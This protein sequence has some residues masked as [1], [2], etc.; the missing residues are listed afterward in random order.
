MTELV[1]TKLAITGEDRVRA[2]YKKVE[3]GQSGLAAAGKR[4]N[5][6]LE[7]Q[8]D[9]LRQ[10]GIRLAVIT[11][12]VF[13][14]SGA[15]RG[16]QSAANLDQALQGL[17]SLAAQSGRS[18]DA[19]LK[20]VTAITKQQLALSG[21]VRQINLALASGFS[22]Q[23]IEDLTD[24]ATKASRVLGVA[25]PDA[26]DRLIKAAAKQ[27]K[28]LL[29]EIGIF[30]R[31]GVASQNY[32]LA[33]GKNVSEL[34]EFE[35]SQAFVNA[36]IDEGQRKFGQVGD[37]AETSAETFNRLT[38]SAS[39]LAT[40]LGIT[41]ANIAAPFARAL[42]DNKGVMV[43]AFAAL[44]GALTIA[45]TPIIGLFA[46]G[47]ATALTAGL[48]A[49]P[50]AAAL[51]GITAVFGASSGFAALTGQT[52][53]FNEL[54]GD[55]GNLLSRLISTGQS[56]S[57]EG[58]ISGV[59]NREIKALEDAGKALDTY[60]FKRNGAF[61]FIIGAD[62]VQRTGE[63]VRSRINEAVLGIE[64]GEAAPENPIDAAYY[65]ASNEDFIKVAQERIRAALGADID[66][67]LA[68]GLQ[69]QIVEILREGTK[70][71]GRE[72]ELFTNTIIEGLL[73]SAPEIISRLGNLSQ[74]FSA[75]GINTLSFEFEELSKSLLRITTSLPGGGI[76][77][78]ERRSLDEVE[79]QADAVRAID[80]NL[81]AG[82]RSA[83]AFQ[84]AQEASS[85]TFEN[86][87]QK[88]AVAEGSL[89]DYRQSAITLGV[90]REE[91]EENIAT[92]T[93]DRRLIAL[94]LLASAE[95]DLRI[96]QDNIKALTNTLA[97]DKERL[98]VLRQEKDLQEFISKTSGS[99]N[100]LL[101]LVNTLKSTGAQDFEIFSAI[102]DGF[103]P[104]AVAEIDAFTKAVDEFADATGATA[105][106]K[107]DIL[108]IS[109]EN[110]EEGLASLN[111]HA[112]NI[113]A[114]LSAS[115][116]ELILRT[117]ELLDAGGDTLTTETR[118]NLL[119]TD[120]LALL[121][122]QQ[123]LQNAIGNSAKD[124]LGTLIDIATNLE[125]RI[126]AK[127]SSVRAAI[128][129]IPE[130]IRKL[131]R[132]EVLIQTRLAIDIERLEQDLERF[133]RE[134]LV[135]QL[136]LNAE[137]QRE[138]AE[139]NPTAANR[140][141]LRQVEQILHSA[142]LENFDLQVKQLQDQKKLQDEDL[143]ARRDAAAE[144]IKSRADATRQRYIQ[145][146]D[147]LAQE[148]DNQEAYLDALADIYNKDLEAEDKLLAQFKTD[149]SAI[150]D[151]L[152]VSQGGQALNA[153]FGNVLDSSDLIQ[154]AREAI[155]RA[156]TNLYTTF[157]TLLNR[158]DE[159]TAKQ[160]ANS[161]MRFDAEQKVL[162]LSNAADIAK[163]MGAKDT[164][165]KRKEYEE[166]TK[167]LV[168][169]ELTSVQKLWQD[170]F[171]DLESNV[172]NFFDKAFDDI[173]F[174]ERGEADP[175]GNRERID[176]AFDEFSKDTAR[177]LFSTF[178][179]EPAGNF[180]KDT[181][182]SLFNLP[183]DDS[184]NVRSLKDLKMRDGAL[185]TYLVGSDVA[186]G[187]ERYSRP[188][189]YY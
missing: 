188:R 79:G 51:F 150:I 180:V 22:N 104:T 70:F 81:K 147:I 176:D 95:E 140:E 52:R 101:N 119:H 158:H 32:A 58:I 182:S 165:E 94:G 110:A 114:S 54:L 184:E 183:Q 113:R 175:R 78:L 74:A 179:S 68:A 30:A 62:D 9:A 136:Q 164:Y 39:D 45:L 96:T 135:G 89:N 105:G 88:V 53:Q 100:E 155:N 98:A 111:S 134:N 50:I 144:D 137:F 186:M 12:A 6:T 103:D 38:A 20:N 115:G 90:R 163:V 80:D 18:G 125:N 185:E 28:E 34:T 170:F 25:L 126:E 86:F 7:R 65:F 106:L 91:L 82:I 173:L 142:M 44:F 63:D 3:A 109:I 4:V 43:A 21:T 1:L 129:R 122:Q 146:R 159:V 112:D 33:L 153:T 24:V 8:R 60:T 174:G 93:G 23:Q 19:I 145:Q 11:G 116:T 85:T 187:A 87:S 31:V 67:R 123:A 132:E 77:L 167:D 161:E 181:F 92:L 48:A 128:A 10:T 127:L 120:R 83:K 66:P 157:A 35:K 56:A 47:I 15:F 130:E 97:L 57:S 121:G 124:Q 16:L 118:I 76:T 172:S 108:G 27:E 69:F 152:I 73:N 40:E 131:E 2:G 117:T 151:R 107:A 46:R 42:L 55:T 162:D 72:G 71:E 171:R 14:I 143:A 168:E 99:S 17:N 41:L 5:D 160:L 141:S 102:L 149:F 133:T 154:P 139:R 13:A 156:R 37:T 148:L 36:V 75:L 26:Y 166:K 177:D 61:S 59:I 189:C 178:V 138:R 29:D 64:G 49:N 169:K 84:Q